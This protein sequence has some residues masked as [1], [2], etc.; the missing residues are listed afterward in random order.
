MAI[1]ALLVRAGAHVNQPERSGDGVSTPLQAA[2]EPAAQ[3][4]RLGA[5]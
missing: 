3:L 5:R 4:R 1:L 2:G